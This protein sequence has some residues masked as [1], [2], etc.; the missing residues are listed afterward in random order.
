MV[1]GEAPSERAVYAFRR[2]VGLFECARR[3]VRKIAATHGNVPAGELML[4]SEGWSRCAA[5][6][7][8][9]GSIFGRRADAPYSGGEHS[10]AQYVRPRGSRL[11]MLRTSPR[12]RHG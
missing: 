1:V 9:S 12:E 4:A 2:A 8:V 5:L 10:G 6:A 11:N 7:G 3:T